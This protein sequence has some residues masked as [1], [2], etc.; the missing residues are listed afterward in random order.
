MERCWRGAGERHGAPR[1]WP[2]DSHAPSLALP[3]LFP[4]SALPP[5]IPLEFLFAAPLATDPELSPDGAWVSFLAPAGKDNAL[6]VWIGPV[7]ASTPPRP[8][9]AEG[10]WDMAAGQF[11]WTADS[12][13]ILFLY[14]RT[15]GSRFRLYRQAL[16]G[17]APV[18]LLPRLGTDRPTGE[19]LQR[20]GASGRPAPTMTRGLNTTATAS[21]SAHGKGMWGRG[22][23]I[24]ELFLSPGAPDEALVTVDARA[25][26]L[27]DVWRLNLTSGRLVADMENPGD[28]VSW[29]PD[30]VLHVRG[31]RAALPGGWSTLRVRDS[32]HGRGEDP[33]A[34]NA[35]AWPT[36]ATWGPGDVFAPIAGPGQSGAAFTA[37]GKAM[38]ALSSLNLPA[39]RL[40]KV[41]TA[42]GSV[43]EAA[44][45]PP[46]D[47]ADADV[48]EVVIDPAT[49]GPSAAAADYLRR[50]WAALTPSGAA[51]ID[52]LTAAF[53]GSGDW[54]ILSTTADGVKS[55]VKIVSDVA[56]TRYFY[57]D[58]SSGGGAVRAGVPELANLAAF[59]LAPQAGVV[60]PA[61]DGLALPCYLTL[62]VGV[63]AANATGDLRLPLV[64][65]VR[66]SPWGREK[67]G[68]G[69]TIQML[70][71]R[72]FAVLQV[73]SRGATGFGKAFAAAGAGAWAGAM[74]DDYEDAARWAVE[75]ARVAEYGRVHVAGKGYGGYSALALAT[76][77][78]AVFNA[79]ASSYGG[80]PVLHSP[81]VMWPGGLMQPVVAGAY[82]TTDAASAAALSPEIAAARA[83]AASPA[84]HLAGLRL[85]GLLLG[86]GGRD[87]PGLIAAT[88]AFAADAAA[89]NAST[90]T[91]PVP[92][93][94]LVL[95]PNLAGAALRT[96]EDRLDWGSRGEQFMTACGGGRAG[97]PLDVVGAHVEVVRG[98]TL[99]PEARRVDPDELTT[100]RKVGT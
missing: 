92:D 81:A 27:F 96:D 32:V 84:T 75:N 4:Q 30:A 51:D 85:T 2:R 36:V 16:D 79:C 23:R 40:L 38:W 34:V 68:F 57:Y 64:I 41:S 13:Y 87:D 22:M 52:A 48:T 11:Q 94:R 31:A 18:D 50:G 89:G 90:A 6:N 83:A 55:A 95:Y 97:P 29:T 88:R 24:A 8:L 77:R 25:P 80:P 7:N 73:N 76:M 86:A 70:A 65:A 74:L 15:G 98:P 99:G 45:P 1:A 82:N 35:S 43:L 78:P 28:V 44:P 5:L 66:A 69:S 72:G 37:D 21:P 60:I 10:P 56:P 20:A 54:S 62:P 59:T 93:V 33:R 53:N 63:D 47:V 100:Q 46:A 49:G 3:S 71:N 9:T 42:D 39:A 14:D 26:D 91:P 17:S 58:R 67:W 19:E 12:R 61:R